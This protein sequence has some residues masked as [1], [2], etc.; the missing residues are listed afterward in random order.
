MTPAEQQAQAMTL[1]Q[2][3]MVWQRAPE[4]EVAWTP[5]ERAARAE[6]DRRVTLMEHA[7]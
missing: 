3:A 2:L 6:Y 4:R 1:I 5:L 7:A